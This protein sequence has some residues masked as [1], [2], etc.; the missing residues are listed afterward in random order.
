MSALPPHL[1]EKLNKREK[2]GELRKLDDF[3]DFADFFS[4]DYLGLSKQTFPITSKLEG[5]TGSRLISGNS[6]YTE[7]VEQYIA[8]FFGYDSGLI[9]NS[10]YDANLGIYSSVPQ[11]GDT[12]I[13]DELCHASIRDGLR[14]NF[15]NKK[16]FKHNDAQDLER[17]LNNNSGQVYVAVESVYSMHG[18]EAPL[19]EIS[20]LC[21]KYHALLILDEAHSAGVFGNQG[22]GLSEE[23]DD[24]VFI[25][26]VTFGKAYG[27]HGAIALCSDDTRVFLYNFARSF[28]YTT[29]IPGSTIERLK[30][31]VDYAA[32]ADDERKIL[33]NNL[34]Y[35]EKEMKFRNPEFTS[36]RSPV[37]TVSYPSISELKKRVKTANDA[38][39]ALKAILPPTVPEGQERIR[40]CIH[41]YNTKEEINRLIEVLG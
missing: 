35:F 32:K 7:E 14:L 34:D 18:D 15:A 3:S 10:G 6:N 40:I 37:Q 11:R 36:N 1:K 30:N 41:S 13:Y 2:D 16:S 5:S 20:Q 24:D 19:G 4:N 25:K 26:L 21:K 33:S 29:A 9:F 28:I 12:V 22:K 27:S 38:K 39:I 17:L 23:I 31:V 8:A